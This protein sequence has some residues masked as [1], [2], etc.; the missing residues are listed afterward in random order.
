MHHEKAYFSTK[1]CYF[2]IDHIKSRF[3]LKQLCRH[4]EHGHVQTFLFQFF[5]IFKFIKNA[6]QIKGAYA[7]ESKKASPLVGV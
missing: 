6:F 2:N 1:F 5:D 7:P 4:V 3:L